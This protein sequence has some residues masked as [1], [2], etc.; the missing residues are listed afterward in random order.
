MAD[1]T[2]A[3]IGGDVDGSANAEAESA[4]AKENG[5]ER[6]RIGRFA[7]RAGDALDDGA[8]ERPASP[9][10]PL[11]GRADRALAGVSGRPAETIAS[12]P[13]KPEAG[14][15][16]DAAPGEGAKVADGLPA[17]RSDGTRQPAGNGAETVIR[18]HHAGYEANG[19][20]TEHWISRLLK[21]VGVD[22][23]HQ[24]AKTFTVH[25]DRPPIASE[26]GVAVT[27]ATEWAGARDETSAAARHAAADSLKS[28]LLQLAG[29][30]DVPPA[31]KEEAL[32]TLQYITGQQLLLAADRHSVFTHVTLFIPLF[33]A[34]GQYAASVHVQSRKGRR[35]EIDARNCRLLFDLRM[36]SLGDTLVEAQVIDRNVY[37]QVHN[38]HPQIAVLLDTYRHEIE[39]ALQF[40]G[41]RMLSLQCVPFREPGDAARSEGGTAVFAKSA[42]MPAASAYHVK[43]Y[44]GVDVRV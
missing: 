19:P 9:L 26:P 35:G 4:R 7:L 11:P 14:S 37:L 43:P 22:Y 27:D 15:A 25:R 2:E 30:T 16:T 10:S 42:F 6:E 32:Q 44:K 12:G 3:A 13:V 17:E 40:S 5:A 41:Y 20:R 29:A 33:G 31:L 18:D 36:K 23:E 34:D 39:S 38:D 24:V 28:A 8:G 1:L 21:T